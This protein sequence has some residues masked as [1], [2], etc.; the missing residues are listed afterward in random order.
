MPIWG[1]EFFNNETGNPDA[2]RA[3]RLLITRLRD[4]VQLLQR[5]EI[6][7]ASPE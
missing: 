1:Q 6:K 7:G 4:Y 2:E 5:P 3:T